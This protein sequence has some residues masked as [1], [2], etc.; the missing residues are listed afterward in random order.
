MP[1]GITWGLGAT[2]PTRMPH[3]CARQY[4]GEWVIKDNTIVINP[5]FVAE[6]GSIAPIFS[7]ISDPTSIKA[8]GVWQ[9]S[10][11]IFTCRCQLQL[12]HGRARCRRARHRPQSVR[13][14]RVGWHPGVTPPRQRVRVIKETTTVTNTVTPP[15]AAGSGA[16]AESLAF[17]NRQL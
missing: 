8:G 4:L 1:D 7:P 2:F 13:V 5:P 12:R 14:R 15:P 17:G 6:D 16:T 9:A 11:G 3:S 10:N